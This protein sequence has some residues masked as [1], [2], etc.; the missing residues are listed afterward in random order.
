[1]LRYPLRLLLTA[2]LLGCF[3]LASC[4]YTEEDEE[5]QLYIPKADKVVKGVVYRYQG[6]G[7]G[8]NGM[9]VPIG[10]IS[11]DP[12]Y[13]PI[14][15]QL[16]NTAREMGI[17][18]SISRAVRAA[19]WTVLGSSPIVYLLDRYGTFLQYDPTSNTVVAQLDLTQS[20]VPTFPQRMALTPDGNF[21]FITVNANQTATS[22]GTAYVLVVNVNTFS[23]ASTITLPAATVVQDLAITP[24]GSLAYAVT[25]PYSGSG[26]SNV[27]VIDVASRAITSTIPFTDYSNLGQ[28]AITPDGSQAYL[29]NSI[30]TGGFTI[31]V[32][33]LQS[34]TV[35]PPLQI[36]FGSGKTLTVGYQ[37]SY[38]A[39]H[40]DGTRLYLAPVSGGPVLI[41]STATG[42]VANTIPLDTAP[43][44]VFGAHPTFTR[45]G[46]YLGLMSG[47][48][49]FVYVNTSTDTVDST[50][51]LDPAPFGAIRNAG[52]FFAPASP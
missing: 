1:M 6:Y 16:Q 11:G 19:V 27:Y 7:T 15:Q 33:D 9:W 40:P 42:A 2:A 21:A 4:S 10:T 17:T 38:L 44:P 23:I 8:G 24:D 32:L 14:D 36:F 34:N 50:I 51:A 28:I 39:M 29:V 48:N 46:S 43:G 12:F 35:Q 31:P 45:D 18:G 25:Q 5:N 3:A 30:D 49:L 20:G 47:P 41:V 13:T 22:G 37:P 26:P 52:P